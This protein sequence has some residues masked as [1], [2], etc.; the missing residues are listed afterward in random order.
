MFAYIDDT[1]QH[2]ISGKLAL[3][4]ET[5]TLPCFFW[6]ALRD[7]SSSFSEKFVSL[8][9]G[10]QTEQDW[11]QLPLLNNVKPSLY[12]EI[13]LG[14]KKKLKQIFNLKLYFNVSM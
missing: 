8:P 6:V 11:Y 12:L 5:W 7:Y 10:T 1:L 4:R 3:S 14:N 2:K 9:A 13:F